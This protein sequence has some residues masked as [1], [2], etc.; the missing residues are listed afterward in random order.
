VK[1]SRSWGTLEDRHVLAAPTHAACKALLAYWQ[2]KVPSGGLPQRRDIVPGEIPQ[3]LPYLMIIEPVD[4][5]SDWKYRLVG[6]ALPKR[7][8]FDWTG[9]KLTELLDA[10]PASLI[11]GFYNDVASRRT[12]AF[13]TGRAMIEGRDHIVY[14]IGAFPILG[15]DGVT[16]WILMGV[17]FHN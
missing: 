4:G 6:T 2:S 7:Y 10:A 16:V 11:I 1:A 14:E 5:S 17:F 8:G 15:T 9:M 3:L 12:P 13:A